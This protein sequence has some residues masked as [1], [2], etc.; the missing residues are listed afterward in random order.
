MIDDMEERIDRLEINALINRFMIME[1][2]DKLYPKGPRKVREIQK[3]IREAKEN[4]EFR[5]KE[6][7]KERPFDE[8]METMMKLV[9]ELLP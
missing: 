9:Q 2:L 3:T 5:L 4:I 8:K 6:Y 1:I 7:R